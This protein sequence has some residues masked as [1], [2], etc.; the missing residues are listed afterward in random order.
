VKPSL[1]ARHARRYATLGYLLL[2]HRRAAPTGG[3]WADL[4]LDLSDHSSSAHHSNGSRAPASE[5]EDGSATKDAEELVSEL[6]RMGPTF[7]KLGQLLSTRPD[8]LPPP[9]LEALSSLQEDVDPLPPG[10]AEKVIEEELNVRISTAFESFDSTPFGAASLGQVHKAVLRDGRRVAVKVQR[11][12]IRRQALDDMEVIIELAAFL[13]EHSAAASRFGFLDMAEEFRQTL[14]QEL[15]YRRE[16]SNQRLLGQQLAEFERIVVPQPINDY[17]TSRVLTM[18]YVEGRSVG[19]IS[20][21]S[22]TEL[23]LSGLAE[24]LIGAYLDQVL[25]HGFFHADPHPGNV[26]LTTDGRIA[27]VD[28][29]MVSR[30]S[31]EVQ[32]HLLRLLLAVSAGHSSDALDALEGL[33]TPLDDYNRE[34]LRAR[35]GELSLRYQGSV[36]GELEAGGLLSELAVACSSSGLRPDPNLTLLARALMSL[37][38]VA[39]LLDPG[40]EIDQAINDHATRVMR[41]RMMDAI[42]PAHV[43][44][45]V[46]DSAAFVEAL[47]GRLNK[48]LASISE[49]KFTI[50]LEGLDEPA[51]LRGAQKLANRV[52]TGVLIAAFVLAAALFS[53][54]KSADTLW[55]YPILTIIFL[56]LAIAG[57]IW[58]GIGIVRGD[59]RQRGGPR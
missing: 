37:D 56:G 50:N 12:G 3:G 58:L 42:S 39:H 32:E 22:R 26:M 18:D 44:R 20:P 38:Q 6:V 34:H 15:D 59:V 5:V 30:L 2:K 28:L 47:P 10:E 25:V 51:L 4:D 16:A 13:D 49:G 45:A 33:G 17:T 40:I 21:L 41:H 14:I 24:E 7:V 19:S 31:A 43:M 54:A 27:L 9:Y 46:L 8:L 35:V 57:A 53:G 1:R 29:G 36:V 23:D 55:G 48:V 52:A 11:P